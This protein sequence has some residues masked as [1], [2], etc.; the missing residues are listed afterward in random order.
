[1]LGVPI[2][3]IT[4]FLGSRFGPLLE[5]NSHIRMYRDVRGYMGLYWD[6]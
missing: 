5:R 4:A 2:I 3:R 6:M 1:M